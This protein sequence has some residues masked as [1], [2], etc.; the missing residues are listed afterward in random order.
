MIYIYYLC[1]LYNNFNIKN[2]YIKKIKL[3]I[4]EF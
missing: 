2:L 3:R 1:I 4:K